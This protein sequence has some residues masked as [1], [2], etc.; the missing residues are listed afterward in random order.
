MA[1]KKVEEFSSDI[2]ES[3]REV[4]QLVT[5]SI[6]AAH[7]RDMK[8][9]QNT[10]TNAM[11]LFKSHAEATRALMQK[12]EQQQAAWQKLAPEGMGSQWME[13]Y[14]GMLRAPFSFYQQAL[15][16]ADKTTQQGLETFQKAV[17][18]FQEAAQ[19][20]QHAARRTTKA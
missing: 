3:V 17:E 12:L 15:E 13:T 19:Q 7:E 10:F 18:E 20:P 14:L 16:A 4:T 11:E 2:T 6:I 1:E 5:K 9:V 8:F